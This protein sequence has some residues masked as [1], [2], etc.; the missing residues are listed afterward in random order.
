M[1]KALVSMMFL[2]VLLFLP[3]AAQAKFPEKPITVVVPFKP[4]GGND[5]VARN[6]AAVG[7]KY[8]GVPVIVENRPGGQALN[9]AAVVAQ[10][11]PDGYTLLINNCAVYTAAPHMFK[12][13][14]DP[15]KAFV[16]I[17]RLGNTPQVLIASAHSPA[18]DFE[19]FVKYV[20]EN[21]GKVT[22]GCAGLGDISGLQ[23]AEAFNKMKLNVKLV[24]LDGA[25][26]TVAN[27]LGGHIMYGNVSDLG[28]MRLLEAG[29][30]KVFFEFGGE[31][32]KYLRALGVR[33]LDELG[34]PGTSIPYYRLFVAPAGTP[35]EVVEI[36]RQGFLKMAG[37]PEVLQ[38]FDAMKTPHEGFSIDGGQIQ[39]QL[40]E[41]YKMFGQTVRRLGL[42]QKK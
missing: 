17:L 16:P 6:I 27:V 29:K 3:S 18:Q 42:D 10:A 23:I 40:E 25:A 22:I 41:E 21:P 9:G 12:V 24:P 7:E 28:A 32:G 11:K 39:K 19:A 5:I 15:M 35:P 36:L 8:F 38:R 20:K 14:Y 1:K 4:G 26:E 30:L 31:P 13:P 37:D 33:T 34:Y 2:G